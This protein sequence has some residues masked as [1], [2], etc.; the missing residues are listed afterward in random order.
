MENPV[1]GCI[2]YKRGI[3]GEESVQADPELQQISQAR[4]GYQHMRAGLGK[5]EIGPDVLGEKVLF[6][7]K[8]RELNLPCCN[9]QRICKAELNRGLPLDS[10]TRPEHFSN[11]SFGST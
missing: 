3:R 10:I 2:T 9:C 7:G 4:L 6:D 5:G 11:T 8:V 1:K